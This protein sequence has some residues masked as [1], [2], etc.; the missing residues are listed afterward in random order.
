VLD[1]KDGALVW[2][3]RTGPQIKE[4]PL[5]RWLNHRTPTVEKE[6]IYVVHPEGDLVCFSASSGRELWRTSYANKFNAKRPT[7]GF[8]DTPLVDGDRLICAPGG[9]R[10]ALAAL[11]KFTGD[12]VWK[13]PVPGDPDASYGATVVTTLAGD[14]QYI[15]NFS[16]GPAGFATTGRLL[17]RYETKPW[18]HSITPLVTENRIV[19]A[20]RTAGSY[21]ALA[22]IR[23]G[24]VLSVKETSSQRVNLDPF[25]DNGLLLANRLFTFAGGGAPICIDIQ[26]GARSGR[27]TSACG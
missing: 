19:A 17:W 24:G 1:E 15:R 5:M 3:Q 22:I 25:H 2:A 23:D 26:S 7:F 8:A 14:K 11:D 27:E 12:V 20:D 21:L 10:A 13:A 18:G 4:S 16:T 9:R 6:R